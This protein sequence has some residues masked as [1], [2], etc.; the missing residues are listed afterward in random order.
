MRKA[1]VTF[2]KNDNFQSHQ[3]WQ[4]IIQAHAYE[5]LFM[6]LHKKVPKM[7]RRVFLLIES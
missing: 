4:H 1:V 2:L 7:L 6:F 5:I 3:R